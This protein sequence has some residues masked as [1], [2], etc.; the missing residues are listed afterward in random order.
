MYSGKYRIQLTSEEEQKLERLVRGG[1]HNASVVT[2]AR[3]LLLVHQRQKD[4]TIARVLKVGMA[5]IWRLK[6]RYAE[7]GLA[8]ALREKLQKKG[9]S[10]KLD[11][12]GE[13]RL[14]QLACSQAPEGAARW[15]LSMLQNRLVELGVVESIGKTT[16]Y[17]TLKKTSWPHISK[18]SG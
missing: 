3:V 9:R 4:V 16:V 14:I 13:A 7:G 5:T 11:G 6:K 17:D 12:R 8:G 2:R 1:K 18:S 15:T 10:R